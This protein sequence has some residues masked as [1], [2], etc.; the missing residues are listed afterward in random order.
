MSIDLHVRVTS[1]AM[2]EKIQEYTGE[3]GLYENPSELVRDALRRF[4]SSEENQVNQETQADQNA[5]G[6]LAQQSL[7]N[8]KYFEE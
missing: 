4:F 1:K 6:A 8:N 7:S 2:Q 5:I 3:N